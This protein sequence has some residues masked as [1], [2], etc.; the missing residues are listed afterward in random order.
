[1]IR[2]IKSVK[3]CL[4]CIIIYS[5]EKVVRQSTDDNRGMSLV[6]CK[7]ILQGYRSRSNTNQPAQQSVF[8]FA[9]LEANN[10][11]ADQTAGLCRCCLHA[12]TAGFLMKWLI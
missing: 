4:G 1:M 12:L 7:L 9:I 5:L 3:V 6:T 2:I 11:G 10:E 8:K